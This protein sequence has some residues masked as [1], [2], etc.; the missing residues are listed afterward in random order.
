M[1][2]FEFRDMIL[3]R[4]GRGSYQAL[5]WDMTSSRELMGKSH[6]ITKALSNKLF[7]YVKA[8]EEAND[9]K[10]LIDYDKEGL[11]DSFTLVKTNP[12]VFNDSFVLTIYRDTIAIDHVNILFEEAKDELDLHYD[13][14][15][16]YGTYETNRY[17]EGHKLLFSEY[18]IVELS[19]LHK[20]E[21]LKFK[22]KFQN[23]KK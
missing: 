17:E 14:H 13:Y 4:Q 22:E 1:G 20:K 6:S 19:Q 10:V 12:Y 18:L 7:E 21:N 9:I 8:Y 23:I 15:F 3:E 5:V 11:E 2:S 16:A